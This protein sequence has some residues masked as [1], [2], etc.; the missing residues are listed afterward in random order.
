MTATSSPVQP[1]VVFPV[2]H[3]E[4]ILAAGLASS[5]LMLESMLDTVENG[6]RGGEDPWPLWLLHSFT[7]SVRRAR[8]QAERDAILELADT[9]PCKQVVV[10]DATAFAFE[11]MPYE[12]YPRAIKKLQ[13]SGL[14]I[15]ARPDGMPA[16]EVRSTTGPTPTI[17]L[18]ASLGMTT[19]K[20]AAQAAHALGLWGLEVTRPELKAWL[21][22]PGA[23]L[24][25][26]PVTVPDPDR[27]VVRDSGLTEIAA[28]SHTAAITRF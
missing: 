6:D 2:G 21:E 3:E 27:I 17:T 4:T 7:K 25:F 12:K 11:P 28:G 24:E 20:S 10:G 1:I 26:G 22:D 19:G 23:R 14:D 15:A 8:R 18:N 5:T 13:V 9:M 16:C